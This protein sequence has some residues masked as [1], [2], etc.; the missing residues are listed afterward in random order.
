MQNPCEIVFVSMHLETVRVRQS[1]H[2]LHPTTHTFAKGKEY[3]GLLRTF[4]RFGRAGFATPP[5]WWYIALVQGSGSPDRL[6]GPEGFAEES[7]A[8]V[9]WVVVAASPV[10][11]WGKC[12]VVEKGL[13]PGYLI[14]QSIDFLSVLHEAEVLH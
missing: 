10:S 11:D 1:Y 13:V 14:Y 3:F 12:W 9:F 4:L 5:V 2:V 6:V 7:A 8:I